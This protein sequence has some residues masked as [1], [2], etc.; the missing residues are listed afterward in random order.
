MIVRRYAFV[1]EKARGLRLLDVGCGGGVGLRYLR[2]AGVASITAVD[3]CEANVRVASRLAGDVADVRLMDAHAQNF[4]D[5][6]FDIVSCMQVVQYLD[7]QRFIGEAVRVLVPGGSLIVEM[8]N[9]RRRDGF[10]AS[11]AGRSYY[12]AAEMASLFSAAGLTPR[13]YGAFGV[14]ADATRPSRQFLKR[15]KRKVV[16]GVLAIPGGERVKDAIVA[17]LLPRVRVHEVG[18]VDVAALDQS[19]ALHP[20]PVGDVGAGYQMIYVVGRAA[21]CG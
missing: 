7:V 4:P 9:I 2:Q 6:S 18:A 16:D 12:T 11:A 13:V 8:P 10:K 14:P 3:A 1:A 17:R 19:S 20:L 21:G 5:S 15:C